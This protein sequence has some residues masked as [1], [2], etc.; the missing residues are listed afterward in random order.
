MR[1][2]TQEQYDQIYMPGVLAEKILKDPEWQS[3]R[4]FLNNEL[5]EMEIK[6]LNNSIKDEEKYIPLTDGIIRVLKFSKKVQVDE[7][8]G[9]YKW[10]KK[11][12]AYLEQCVANKKSLEDQIAQNKVRIED[13]KG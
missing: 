9:G 4:T 1:K 10:L 2:I 3:F 7:L 8:V 12:I 13:A 11:L 5:T 6:I